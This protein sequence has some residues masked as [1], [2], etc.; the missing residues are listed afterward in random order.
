MVG[1]LHVDTTIDTIFI[2]RRKSKESNKKE[3]RFE[4]VWCIGALLDINFII[5]VIILIE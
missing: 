4:R 3:W 5:I 2:Y 1:L